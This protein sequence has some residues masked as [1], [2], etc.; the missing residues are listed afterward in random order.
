MPQAPEGISQ[1]SHREFPISLH[2]GQSLSQWPHRAGKLVELTVWT[3]T[4]DGKDTPRVLAAAGCDHHA[5][6]RADLL[7]EQGPD[8]W[9]LPIRRPV[10]YVHRSDF[11]TGNARSHWPYSGV[12]DNGPTMLDGET[13]RTLRVWTG[14]PVFPLHVLLVQERRPRARL[15]HPA[16]EVRKR[17]GVTLGGRP[18]VEV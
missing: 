8:S 9:I 6:P 5:H 2:R 13:A 7:H 12:R 16:Q 18:E 10:D 1:Q 15:E 11:L 3:K 4:D 14:G 17:R